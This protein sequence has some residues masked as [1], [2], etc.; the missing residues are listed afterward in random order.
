MFNEHPGLR[1]HCIATVVLT[2]LL[3]GGC[4]G[5]T[6]YGPA[7]D[8]FGYKD[9]AIESDRFRV[10]FR[11]NSATDRETVETYLLY[12]AAELTLEQGGTYFTVV[13]RDL[14][15]SERYV[16]FDY[17]PFG[18]GGYGYYGYHG[19]YYFRRSVVAGPSDSIPITRYEAVAEIVVGGPE[20]AANGANAYDARDVAQ[21]LGPRI[22]RTG[23]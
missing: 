7:T 5:P 8:R 19:G 14:E 9:N 2:V 1:H 10:S 18:Y 21:T 15:K 12:R 17:M 13:A 22:V 3:L 6:P 11:G 20:L 23:N 4:T 16:Q